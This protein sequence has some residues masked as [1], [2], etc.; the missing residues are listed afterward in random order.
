MFKK[1]LKISF[2]TKIKIFFKVK[3]SVKKIV[4]NKIYIYFN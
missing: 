1:K 3:I 2:I 4:L